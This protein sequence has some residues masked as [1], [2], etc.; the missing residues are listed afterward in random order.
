[1]ATNDKPAGT[2]CPICLN[3]NSASDMVPVTIEPAIAGSP[4]TV[5]LCRW[6]VDRIAEAWQAFDHANGI[7]A[8]DQDSSR[9]EPEEQ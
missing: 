8:P 1:M 2:T 5:Q 9:V 6:C 7:D 3:V 4:T